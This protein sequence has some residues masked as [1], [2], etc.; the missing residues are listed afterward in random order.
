MN[1]LTQVHVVS[2]AKALSHARLRNYR[3]FFGAT[4]DRAAYGLYCWNDA[5]SVALSR[6]LGFAEIALRNQFHTALS[7]RYGVGATGSHDWYDYLTLNP[8]SKEAIRKITHEWRRVGRTKQQVPRHPAPSPDDV[9]S[10][11]TFGFW[12]TS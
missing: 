6:V 5:I 12:R 7:A 11:L 10:K 2:A 8:K 9:V 3:T 4:D 1:N